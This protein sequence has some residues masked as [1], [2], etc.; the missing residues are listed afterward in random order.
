[1]S[2]FIPSQGSKFNCPLQSGQ[3]EER[4][5]MIQT[6][7]DITIHSYLICNY[8]V[9]VDPLPYFTHEAAYCQRSQVTWPSLKK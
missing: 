6:Q 1:M 8:V 7:K 4:V 3:K 9:Y 2:V 5:V